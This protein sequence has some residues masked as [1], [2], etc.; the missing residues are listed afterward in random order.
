M[1]FELR[2]IEKSIWF[3]SAG[4]NQAFRT[5]GRIYRQTPESWTFVLTKHAAAMENTR[6]ATA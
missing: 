2:S 6:N 5:L 3:E 1:F 4:V